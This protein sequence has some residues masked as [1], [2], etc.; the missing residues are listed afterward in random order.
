MRPMTRRLATVAAAT[1]AA[2]V[3]AVAP[4][5]PSSAASPLPGSNIGGV[6]TSVTTLDWSTSGEFSATITATVSGWCIVEGWTS[7]DIRLSGVPGVLATLRTADYNSCSSSVSFV[8]LQNTPYVAVG[9][10]GYSAAEA[11]VHASTDADVPR[12]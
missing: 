11:P 5:A 1:L 3:A 9:T 7:C 4:A 10:I 2:S 8:G 12:R 6:C